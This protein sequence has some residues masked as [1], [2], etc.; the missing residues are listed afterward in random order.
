MEGDQKLIHFPD[1]FRLNDWS[2]RKFTIFSFSIILAYYGSIVTAKY[3]FDISPLPQL[4]GF[5]T[6]YFLPGF[7]IMRILGIHNLESKN[8]IVVAIGLSISYIMIIGLVLNFLFLY[9]KT[10]LFDFTILTALATLL[11]IK[12]III[13]EVMN[14]NNSNKNNNK[15]YNPL[16]KINNKEVIQIMYL[17]ILPIIS[18]LGCITFDL[19]SMEFFLLILFILILLIPIL[20]VFNKLNQK[21]YPAAVISVSLSLAIYGSLSYPNLFFDAGWEYY[22]SN[23]IKNI[24][25][26]DP[27]FVSDR[28]N[29][30]PYITIHI[31]IISIVLNLNLH[32]IYKILLPVIHSL[33][34]LVIYSIIEKVTSDKKISLFATLIITFI[35]AYY[36]WFT[37]TARQGGGFLFFLLLIYLI[38]E[39]RLNWLQRQILFVFFTISL[40]FSHYGTSYLILSIFIVSLVI[41]KIF[42]ETKVL[43]TSSVIIIMVIVISYYLYLSHSVSFK[44]ILKFVD[45]FIQLL[46][47]GLFTQKSPLVYAYSYSW[48]ISVKITRDLIAILFIFIIIGIIYNLRYKNIINNNIKKYVVLSLSSIM[49]Y[50]VF[51]VAPHFGRDRVL[52]LHLT[53]LVIYFFMGVNVIIKGVIKKLIII[54]KILKINNL[55]KYFEPSKMINIFVVIYIILL[56]SFS[57]GLVSLFIP[58]DYS[59]LVFINKN[60]IGSIEDP[61]FLRALYRTYAKYS[62]ITS[63]IWLSNHWVDSVR[64]Y[65]EKSG[66]AGE[67]PLLP[68]LYLNRTG[69]SPFVETIMIMSN[70][71]ENSY[72]YMRYFNHKLKITF[73]EDATK[74]FEINNIILINKTNK[75]YD[76]NNSCI[77]YVTVRIT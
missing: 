44:A 22:F 75:I 65:V 8:S 10:K 29:S 11:I 62:E 24:G 21:Y 71:E 13:S 34:A 4:L 23:L 30:L 31:P 32:L 68:Y 49:L 48:P 15:Y 77:Y 37:A 7:A 45:N 66:K 43:K 52:V 72:L 74:I 64:I 27:N 26:W 69:I 5:I 42:K 25:Y 19:L 54:L 41:Q 63:G 3:F 61:Y 9:Y 14:K 59:P 76:N 50:P 56:F 28:T 46:S 57:S 1:I 2:R 12:I 6:F 73:S 20:V 58:N 67:L 39:Q 51:L 38:F 55:P 36:T 60:K 33:S 47:L 16:L 18:F 35:P 17:I 70:F 40:V 53:F